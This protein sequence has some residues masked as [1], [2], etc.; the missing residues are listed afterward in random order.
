MASLHRG[1]SRGLRKLTLPC[2]LP[3]PQGT[4]NTFEDFP[5]R[6]A[7]SL[8]SSLSST[9]VESLVYPAYRTAGALDEA[10]AMFTEWLISNVAEREE[11]ALQE[12][13]KGKGTWK[14]RE[15]ARIVLMAHRSVS[16]TLVHEFN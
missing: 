10:V 12:S 4:D 13:S 16:D 2:C 11:A 1:P 15:Q 6:I 7:Y 9:N 3:P 8:S 5:K 14:D